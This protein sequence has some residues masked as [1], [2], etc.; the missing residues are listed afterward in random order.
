MGMT[1]NVGL[2]GV[3]EQC[4]L[5][6][7]LF[8]RQRQFRE[9]RLHI[10]FSEFWEQSIHDRESN[11]SIVN[12]STPPPHRRPELHP[13]TFWSGTSTLNHRKRERFAQVCS[14]SEWKLPSLLSK[15]CHSLHTSRNTSCPPGTQRSQ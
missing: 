9:G 1:A 13:S 7:W 3:P 12:A 11:M 6:P 15:E 10:P 4:R 8:V 5:S 2:P 14:Q